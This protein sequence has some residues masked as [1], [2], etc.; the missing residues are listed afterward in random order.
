MIEVI[1]PDRAERRAESALAREERT[2]HRHRFLSISE[3]G[4]GGVRL[5]GRGSL[6]DA[7]TLRAALLPLTAPAPVVDPVTCRESPDPRDHGARLWDALV[8]TAAHALAT[9]LPP[10]SHG[11][12]PRVTVTVPLETLRDQVGTAATDDG[13][14]LSGSAIRRLACD[15]DV[16]PVVLGSHSEVLDVGRLQRLVTAALWRALIARDQRCAFPGCTRPPLMCHAHHI[17]HWADGGATSL[18][19]LVLLC[20]HHHRLIH[21]SPWRVRIDDQ[22]RRPE[23]LPP[24]RGAT[25]PAWTRHRPR[26]T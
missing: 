12:R 18:D 10:E 24:M 7:A 2:A 15:A 17:V 9:D 8:A 21:D 22:D 20:G 6:E 3:D 14:E 26:R 11:A 19:N 1:D 25:Q 13:L 4:A 16:I 5:K 23:F